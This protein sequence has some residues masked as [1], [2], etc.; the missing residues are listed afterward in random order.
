MIHIE[1]SHEETEALDYDAIGHTLKI[2]YRCVSPNAAVRKR[3]F[4]TGEQ[5]EYFD[6]HRGY[7]DLSACGVERVEMVAV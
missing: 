2:E 1:F 7:M 4:L 5:E 6:P 3:A